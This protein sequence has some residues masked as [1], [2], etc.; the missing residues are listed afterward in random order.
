[1]VKFLNLILEKSGYGISSCKLR[2][3]FVLFFSVADIINYQKLDGLNDRS[4]FCCNSE[5]R[6]PNSRCPQG[7]TFSKSS[8]QK[9]PHASLLASGVCGNAWC[10]LDW[11]GFHTY[12]S[13]CLQ[14]TFSLCETLL[15]VS[16]IRILVTVFRADLYNPGWSHLKILNLVTAAKDPFFLNKFTFT[17]SG[18]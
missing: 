10:P 3:S 2:L 13:F 12:L 4:L 14:I 18:D 8:R 16:F 15:P 5:V 1:M 9:S 11:G 17:G 7:H 6:S